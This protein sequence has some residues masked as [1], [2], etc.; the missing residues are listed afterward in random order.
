M[1]IWT[2]TTDTDNGTSTEVF[3]TEDH[4]NARATAIVTN[5]Y[6][7]WLRA[8]EEPRDH[9]DW[10]ET[11]ELLQ[12][13]SGFIDTLVVDEHDLSAHPD[14]EW[15]DKFTVWVADKHGHGTHFVQA[16]IA[17][18]ADEAKAAAIK[19]A[20]DHWDREPDDVEILGV[21]EGD[22]NVIE[23]NEAAA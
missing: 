14:L 17:A 2:I 16:F 21:V 11:Y 13:V 19:E 6:D 3:F 20:C 8:D 1:K 15:A 4:A 5:W 12:D 22:V 18:T 7:D 23:W 9:T 10:M